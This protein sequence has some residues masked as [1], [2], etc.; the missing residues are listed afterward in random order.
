VT[1][2]AW[3]EWGKREV[4][5]LFSFDGVKI[6]KRL[7]DVELEDGRALGALPADMVDWRCVGV[8][9]SPVAR[10]RRVQADRD[11]PDGAHELRAKVVRDALH[12]L[13][14]DSKCTADERRH[15][16]NL[17]YHITDTTA[18]KLG[19]MLR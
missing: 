14:L 1:P 4:P 12:A 15:F 16:G 6:A 19:R 8:K 13:A 5:A 11:A 9:A 7:V 17:S 2:P 18:E 10:F 3:I